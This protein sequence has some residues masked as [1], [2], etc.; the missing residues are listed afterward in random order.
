MNNTDHQPKS[1]PI[2]SDKKQQVR[3]MHSQDLFGRH[4]EMMIKHA[5]QEYRLRITRQNKLIL[6]K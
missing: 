6:T 5:G 2:S 4:K 1:R 3:C